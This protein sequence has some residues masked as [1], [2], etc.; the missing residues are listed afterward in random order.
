MDELEKIKA[1]AKSREILLRR[2]GSAGKETIAKGIV[3][4]Q[5]TQNHPPH[6][7]LDKNGKFCH[8]NNWF[9]SVALVYN[10]DVDDDAHG[11]KKHPML[12]LQKTGS[13]SVYYPNSTEEDFK[14]IMLS[15]S[16]GRWLHKWSQKSN[17]VRF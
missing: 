3:V 12:A 4:I 8:T 9:D 2:R 13:Y 15:G 17:Y 1:D 7:L 14:G 11:G 10:T 6:T 16:S 5:G